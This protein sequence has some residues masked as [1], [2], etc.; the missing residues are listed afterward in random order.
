MQT[1]YK[2]FAPRVG[3]AYALGD[4]TVIRAG[5]GIFY[6]EDIANSTYFDMARN[7]AARV[8]LTSTP[9]DPITWSN[10]IPGGGGTIVQV[11]PPFAWAA[12]YRH[13]TPYT[14]QY[15]LNVQREL[16]QNWALEAGYLGSQS[17][18]LYGFENVNEAGPGPSSSINARRPFAN[19]GVLSYVNDGYAGNYNA[20]SAK[21][22]RRFSQGASVITS[23]TYSK[24]IDN[25]SGTRTQGLDILFPQDSTC[26]QC[27]RSLSSFDV[28]HRWVL[29]AVYDL[30]IGKGKMLGINSS[31]LNSVV[32]GWQVSA[33]TTIQSGVPQTLSS[34]GNV[35]GTN[36]P[37]NDR[38]STSGVGNGYLAKHSF[39]SAGLTW[40]DP[41]SFVLQPQGTFG[42]V[43][44]NTMTTPAFQT[45][46]LAVHKNFPMGYRDGHMLQFRLEAFNVL[47]HPVWGAP[48]GNIQAGKA[49]PGAPA[50]A[51]HDGF[52]VINTTAIDM[53]QLQVGLKYSF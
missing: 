33:N 20:A 41:A 28:H 21:L 37:V 9:A 40:Y 24:S 43:G 36:N 8:D 3:I 51:A 13:A 50:N 44:R 29:G 48:N 4:K 39:V 19:F 26:P 23:Y 1:K 35:A 2:S 45:F 22:T 49:F 11:G 25:S 10:A 42:N 17:R 6:M 27:E 16:T 30:P 53:R 47:N 12:A 52:G 7:I 15:L 38:P 18:H 31:A 34:G 14:M 46:D 32:G 5:F